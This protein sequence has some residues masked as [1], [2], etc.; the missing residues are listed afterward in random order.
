MGFSRPHPE[1]SATL[2]FFLAR[3]GGGLGCGW[4]RSGRSARAAGLGCQLQTQG[5]PKPGSARRK[6]AR[7]RPGGAARGSTRPLKS[8]SFWDLQAALGAHGRGVGDS[9]FPLLSQGTHRK[10]KRGVGGGRRARGPS[11]GH[12]AGS[13]VRPAQA[14]GLNKP[15]WRRKAEGRPAWF[16]STS[17]RGTHGRRESP[18]LCFLSPSSGYWG[19]IGAKSGHLCAA[20]RGHLGLAQ[21][22]VKGPVGA[23]IP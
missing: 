10:G 2:G 3:R 23:W 12:Q 7:G 8:S 18:F 17:S 19:L 14:L 13:S 21:S 11:P 4:M 9:Y 5:L 1:T 20:V 15:G 16:S 6:P 22:V